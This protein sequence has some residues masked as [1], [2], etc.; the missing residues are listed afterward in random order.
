MNSWRT[1]SPSG[2]SFLS[3]LYGSELDLPFVQAVAN[4]L[5]CLYGS[6]L[7]LRLLKRARGFLSCLYGS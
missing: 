5:S 3:C 4:F 1:N 2:A 6:E 7:P